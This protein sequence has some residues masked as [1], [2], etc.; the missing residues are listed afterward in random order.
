MRPSHQHGLE[1]GIIVVACACVL[2]W[3]GFYW[4]ESK[5]SISTTRTSSRIARILVPCIAL[6]EIFLWMLML[7][8]KAT[9]WS[10]ESLLESPTTMTSVGHGILSLLQEASGVSAIACCL[11]IICLKPT[12][13]AA[14]FST[15]LYT[16]IVT[17]MLIE[18][19]EIDG[20]TN[21]SLGSTFAKKPQT[22]KVIFFHIFLAVLM[23]VSAVLARSDKHT[24]KLD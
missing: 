20:V 14:F 13:L 7:G 5:K 19:N 8:R 6:V 2:N 16:S 1:T 11:F 24:L 3:F 22:Q 17:V 12:R 21:F 4:T 9:I 10:E 15:F 18:E 23:V